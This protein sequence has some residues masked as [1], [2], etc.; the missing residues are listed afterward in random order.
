MYKINFNCSF[1]VVQ[2]SS[3]LPSNDLRASFLSCY[4]RAAKDL[5]VEVL[6]ELWSPPSIAALVGFTIGAI[7]KMKS[8]VTE[9]GSPLRVV[10]DSAKLL[11]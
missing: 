4:V 2:I 10:Q 6:K 8:L 5:L 7:Y 3:P 9:E 1:N 11:G